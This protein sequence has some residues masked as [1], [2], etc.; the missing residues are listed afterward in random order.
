MSYIIVFYE[1]K[2]KH[3]K[4]KNHSTAKKIANFLLI[5]SEFNLKFRK[6]S[7]LQNKMDVAFLF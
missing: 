6:L 2:I 7:G 3:M 4:H 5:L 1:A